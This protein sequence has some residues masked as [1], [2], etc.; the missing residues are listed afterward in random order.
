MH[1]IN[2]IDC[3]HCTSVPDPHDD[4]RKVP[5]LRYF[6]HDTVDANA[7]LSI[8]N[9][10]RSRLPWPLGRRSSHVR[11]EAIGLSSAT[12]HGWLRA[13]TSVSHILRYAR[14]MRADQYAP[15]E[16]AR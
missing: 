9:P 16:E 2:S 8:E 3:T 13:P 11:R 1:L 6:V 10:P 14:D 5:Y 15:S 7:G 4:E 12:M